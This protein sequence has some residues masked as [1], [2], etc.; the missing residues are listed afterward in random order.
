M[1]GKVQ[2][3]HIPEIV[4]IQGTLKT[5]ITAPANGTF[6]V[7]NQSDLRTV[8]SSLALGY[9]PP[10]PKQLKGAVYGWANGGTYHQTDC[11]VWDSGKI[12]LVLRNE[13]VAGTLTAIRLLTFWV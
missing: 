10:E 11:I 7:F 9:F 5:S 6:M 2:F 13:G 8:F 1:T 3:Y 4:T 12:S